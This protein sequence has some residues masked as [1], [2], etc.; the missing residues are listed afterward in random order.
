MRGSVAI[1]ARLSTWNTPMVSARCS[2]WYTSGSSGGRCARSTWPPPSL[3]IRI[4]SCSTDIMRRPSRS[5]L[6]MPERGAVVLVPLDDHAAGHGGGLQWHDV[7]ETTG[8]DHH[9]PRVL[10]EVARQILSRVHSA[11]NFRI[12]GAADRSRPRPDAA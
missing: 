4:A 2:D 8:C 11:A 9:A 5:T 3:T 7:V 1:C 10:P 6:T 12:R